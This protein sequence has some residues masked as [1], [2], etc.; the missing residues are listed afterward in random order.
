VGAGNRPLLFLFE[1][2]K[3]KLMEGNTVIFKGCGP[4]LF[5]YTIIMFRC[6]LGCCCWQLLYMNDPIFGHAWIDLCS[7]AI[8][9]P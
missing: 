5:F 8:N 1:R 2:G 4:L 9:I 7:E 3:K 6:H